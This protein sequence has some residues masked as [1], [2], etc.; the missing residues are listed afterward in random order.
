VRCRFE[1]LQELRQ[2]GWL[3]PALVCEFFR[4]ETRL[5]RRKFVLKS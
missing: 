1:Q 4:L 2:F 5:P 3:Y